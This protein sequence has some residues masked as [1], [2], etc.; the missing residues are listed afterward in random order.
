MK[1]VENI[2]VTELDVISFQLTLLDGLKSVLESIRKNHSKVKGK[3]EK[4]LKFDF[5]CAPLSNVYVTFH[6]LKVK[7]FLPFKG[8]EVWKV[9]GKTDTVCLGILFI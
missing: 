9:S 5:W 4:F 8:C 2:Y 6:L 7:G 1:L 3:C